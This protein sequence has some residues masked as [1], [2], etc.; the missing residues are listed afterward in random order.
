MDHRIV[1]PNC[2]HIVPAGSS[3]CPKCGCPTNDD[4]KTVHVI[5]P[6]YSAYLPTGTVLQGKYRINHVLG[7]GGFGITYDGTDLKLQMHIAIKEYFPR[8]VAERFSGNTY[9][10]TC[11]QSAQIMYEQG[12]QNFLKE[13]R[14]MAKFV[15]QEH[16]ISVHDYFV[17]NNTA[18]IIMEYVEGQNLKDYMK[19]HGRL[20][21]DSALRIIAPV[22]EAVEKIHSAGMI[23]RDISP[24][25][26]MVQPRGNIKLL[27]FGSVRDITQETQTLTSMSAVYKKGYSPIEQQTTDMRQGTY[28]DIYAI[29]ATLYEM[30]TGSLPPSPFSRLT[31][32]ETLLPPSKMGVQLY[33]SQEAGILKGLE[34]YGKDRQQTIGELRTALFSRQGGMVGNSN[35]ARQGGM[36]GNLNTADGEG[37]SGGQTDSGGEYPPGRKPSPNRSGNQKTPNHRL[38]AVVAAAAIL[39]LVCAVVFTVFSE[40]NKPIPIS[41]RDDITII[42]GEEPPLHDV[43]SSDTADAAASLDEQDDSAEGDTAQ[44]N[45]NPGEEVTAADLSHDYPEDALSYGGHH[46]YIYEDT[47]ES[48]ED[49]LAKCTERGGYLAV[50]NDSEENEVLYQYML[51]IGREEAFFGLGLYDGVWK[52]IAGDTSDFR[53]WGYNMENEAE[54]NNSGNNELHA[55]LDIHMHDGHWND[56]TFGKKVYTPDA[57]PYKDRYAYICEWDN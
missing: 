24:S 50:I 46:Y 12:M 33:A 6:G 43:G 19:Q 8:Q 57:R 5:P 52:Y 17:E 34:V 47:K 20:S 56:T 7:Q 27:D 15:G 48:W 42:T 37:F 40:K 39:L 38:L 14:N 10:V 53:D 45:T 32:E 1:C 23:H 28:T 29:C 21:M 31:G 51:S 18:Y 35:T 2:S 41:E 13:A 9:N 4:E 22:M 54:P 16:F 55:E 25:N 11:T 3:F 49:A 36:I 30:V 44:D 26:I